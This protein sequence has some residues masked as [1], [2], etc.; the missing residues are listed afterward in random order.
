[1]LVTRPYDDLTKFNATVRRLLA[2]LAN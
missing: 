1:V 2:G